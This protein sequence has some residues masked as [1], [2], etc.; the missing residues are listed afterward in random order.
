MEVDDLPGRPTSE[1]VSRNRRRARPWIVSTRP[2]FEQVI[3]LHGPAVLRF[4]TAQAGLD[5]AEDVFQET[6]I[7]ALRAYDDVRDIGAI[8]SW[9]F[10]IASRKAVDAHRARARAPE[11]VADPEPTP[12]ADDLELPDRAIWREVRVLPP[13]QREA[14]ALRYVAD[15]SHREI[16][17]A[18]GTSEA[19]ARRNVYEGLERL[20]TNVR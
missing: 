12:A 4:C 11:P 18:M 2:P 6:M 3:E 14:V 10:A 19:A 17:E 9:L 16:A 13:K 8:R 5:R 1:P 7:A 15:L 20:R